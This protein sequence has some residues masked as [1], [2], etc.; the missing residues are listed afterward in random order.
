MTDFGSSASE[1]SE[2]HHSDR[3]DHRG[4]ELDEA[5]RD[6]P[7]PVGEHA[8]EQAADAELDED[9]E[10]RVRERVEVHACRVAEGGSWRLKL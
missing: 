10:R 5:R 2:Q 8:D 1:F 3:R 4:A 9:D 6:A 7:A